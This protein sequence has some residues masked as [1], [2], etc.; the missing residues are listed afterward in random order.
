MSEFK[1]LEAIRNNQFMII[2]YLRITKFFDNNPLLL[3]NTSISFWVK[4]VVIISLRNASL[5]NKGLYYNQ[6]KIS[7]YID[8]F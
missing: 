4:V 3:F 7:C 1:P 6:S 2:I 8:I 5:K